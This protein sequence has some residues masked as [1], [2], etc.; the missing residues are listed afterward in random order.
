M[1]EGEFRVW[2]AEYRDEG[3]T[4][5]KTP[6]GVPG[7]KAAQ[8][9]MIGR[10]DSHHCSDFRAREADGERRRLIV[11]CPTHPLSPQSGLQF[12]LVE[13]ICTPDDMAKNNHGRPHQNPQPVEGQKMGASFGS[14]FPYMPADVRRSAVERWRAAIHVETVDH[15]FLGEQPSVLKPLNE[16]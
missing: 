2:C 3:S 1:H 8:V 16:A 6:D 13:T 10:R 15:R 12:S 14:H 9:R 11:P 7:D 4:A 5:P